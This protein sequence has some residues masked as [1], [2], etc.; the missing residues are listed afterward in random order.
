MLYII[1]NY[2]DKVND[3]VNKELERI[4]IWLR[5]NKLTINIKKTHYMMFHRTRI[6]HDTIQTIPYLYNLIYVH[7]DTFT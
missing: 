3:I 6:K 5:A 2:Y 7:C 4:N 1:I